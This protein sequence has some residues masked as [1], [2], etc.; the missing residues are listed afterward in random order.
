MGIWIGLKEPHTDEVVF[1]DNTTHNLVEMADAC[2]LYKPLWRPDEVG[3]TYSKDLI[4]HLSKG[5]SEL[6]ANPDKYQAYN[7]PNGWGTY[8]GLVR[9]VSSIYV[10]CLDNQHLIVIVDR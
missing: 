6:V 9:F 7:S 4:P 10:A 8:Q 1:S 2:G 3:I 5:L